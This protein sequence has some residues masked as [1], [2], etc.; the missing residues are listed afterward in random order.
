MEERRLYLWKQSYYE[1]EWRVVRGPRYRFVDGG[2]Y[3]RL[4]YARKALEKKFPDLKIIE[5]NVPHFVPEPFDYRALL[6]L[7]EME[8]IGIDEEDYRDDDISVLMTICLFPEAQV[9]IHPGSGHLGGSEHGPARCFDYEAWE[10]HARPRGSKYAAAIHNLG[11][12]RV[13]VNDFDMMTDVL[14]HVLG[15]EYR[16]DQ[17]EFDRNF[18][19]PAPH[20]CYRRFIE[21]EDRGW[22]CEISHTPNGPAVLIGSGREPGHAMAA[23]LVRFVM[24]KVSLTRKRAGIN[25]PV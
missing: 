6:K 19:Y 14:N 18:T 21:R 23:A 16:R 25:I 2:N 7:I 4:P 5:S 3:S 24:Q 22:T 9:M 11:Y 15:E 13:E 10:A 8:N 17:V 20:G 1:F 12:A